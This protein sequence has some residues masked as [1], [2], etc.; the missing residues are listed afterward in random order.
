MF[1]VIS[2]L[3]GTVVGFVLGWCKEIIENK[4]KVHLTFK[5]S[6]TLYCIEEK[7]D[8]YGNISEK[9]VPIFLANKI[10]LIIILDIFNVGKVGTGITDT[11]I[12]ISKGNDRLYFKPKITLLLNNK[13]LDNISFNLEKNQ[14]HTVKL[15]LEIEKSSNHFFIFED[16][17]LEPKHNNS[18]FDSGNSKNY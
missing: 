10:S 6:S 18:L 3:A 11:S 4:P 14:V 15:A 8:D 13:I 5:N 17:D 9:N 16:I 12:R 2:A 7:C 1:N